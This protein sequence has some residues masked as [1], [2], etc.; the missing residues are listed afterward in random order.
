MTESGDKQQ[1]DEDSQTAADA[2]ENERI[3]DPLTRTDV[4]AVGL[5]NSTQRPDL[6]SSRTAREWIIMGCCCCR[7]CTSW[8]VV[9]LV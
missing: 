6:G 2:A 5:G 7:S 3:N 4:K 9:C 1:R 8:C